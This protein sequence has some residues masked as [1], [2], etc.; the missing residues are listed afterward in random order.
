MRYIF[1]WTYHLIRY[2]YR[3]KVHN[4]QLYCLTD[5]LYNLI[6]QFTMFARAVIVKNFSYKCDFIILKK[7]FFEKHCCNFENLYV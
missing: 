4:G 5:E 3:G 1:D 2:L 7:T 6:G